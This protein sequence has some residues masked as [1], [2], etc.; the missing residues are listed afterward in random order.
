M[1]PNEMLTQLINLSHNLGQSS[2]DYVILGEG[3]TSAKVDDHS[4]WVKASGTEL[5]TV[6]PEGF[7]Q[8][9]FE[10]IL[11]LLDG[12]DLSDDEVRQ[13]LVAAKVDP[14]AKGHPSV[15]TALHAMCL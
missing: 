13:T 1:I 9:Y 4:F 14:K 10:P 12:P 3:N 5:R 11:A 2:N 6:G 8:V 7:V 15:E